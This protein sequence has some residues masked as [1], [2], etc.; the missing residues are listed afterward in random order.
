MKFEARN[1]KFET[2]TKFELAA[3]G[4]R[5]RPIGNEVW[6]RLSASMF[7]AGKPLP[8]KIWLQHKP[9]SFEEKL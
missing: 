3:Y 2:S 4:A 5:R 1:S 7:A 6:E 9:T 8:Q